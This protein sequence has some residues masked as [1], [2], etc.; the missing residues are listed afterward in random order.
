MDDT[1]TVVEEFFRRARSGDFDRLGELFAEH[2][3][4]NV[5]GAQEV[6]WTGRRTTRAEAAAFFR[7]LPTHLHAEDLTVDRIVVDGEHAVALGNM[8]QRVLV[9]GNLFVSPFAFHFTVEHGH[10]TRYNPHEDSLALARTYGA[11]P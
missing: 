7:D 6:P 3:D 11:V 1:R 5:Y 10:I 4:W 9:T 8:R 2:V